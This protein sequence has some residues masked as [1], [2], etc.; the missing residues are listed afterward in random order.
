MVGGVGNGGRPGQPRGADDLGPAAD[1]GSHFLLPPLPP[2]LTHRDA[3][4]RP[5]ASLSESEPLDDES[6]LEEEEEPSLEDD[7]EV[8]SLGDDDVSADDEPDDPDASSSSLESPPQK[9]DLA[10]SA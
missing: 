9:R 5:G 4:P 6:E 2:S 7:D 8:P 10:A 1:R 3:F